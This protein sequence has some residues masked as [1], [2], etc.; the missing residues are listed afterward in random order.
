MGLLLL[1]LY[2][3]KRLYQRFWHSR[4][5]RHERQQAQIGEDHQPGD[6]F[7]AW[8]EKESQVQQECE[9]A[10]AARAHACRDLAQLVAVE[11]QRSP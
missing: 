2:L 11:T 1:R 7:G 8:N 9:A 6:R 3:M 4:R 5:R 10:H